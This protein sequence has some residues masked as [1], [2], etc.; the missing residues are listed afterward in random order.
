M[1]NMVNTSVSLNPFQT[2][3]GHDS[4]QSH[5]TFPSQMQRSQDLDESSVMVQQRH[6]VSRKTDFTVQATESIQRQLSSQ[7]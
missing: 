2:M 5:Q 1:E 7:S 6:V 3:G 4:R